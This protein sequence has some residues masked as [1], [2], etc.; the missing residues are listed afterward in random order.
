MHQ[1]GMVAGHNVACRVLTT[2]VMSQTS[3]APVVPDD[4]GASEADMHN[5]GSQTM[6][7]TRNKVEQGGPSQ[8]QVRHQLDDGDAACMITPTYTCRPQSTEHGS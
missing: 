8:L 3:F 1:L 7:A 6:G 5:N 2:S 4:A